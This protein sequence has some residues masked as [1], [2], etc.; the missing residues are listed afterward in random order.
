MKISL[1]GQVAIVTGSGRGLGRA[2]AMALAERGANVIVND[3]A[4]LAPEAWG[5]LQLDLQKSVQILAMEH[6][7]FAIWK[8]LS[9]EETPPEPT[10]SEQAVMWIMWRRSDLVSRYRA[11]VEPEYE[12]LKLA[13]EG[14]NF[15]VICEK[16]LD[17]FSEEETPMKAVGFLQS[18]IEEEMLSELRT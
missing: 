8:A 17:F 10:K 2:H 3:L 18:W 15:S 1:D 11:L 16:L 6:N 7:G 13:K 4:E 14:E 9:D 12:A 5:T